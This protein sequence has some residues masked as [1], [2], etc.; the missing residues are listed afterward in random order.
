MR[1][2]DVVWVRVRLPH[3]R[4]KQVLDFT[5]VFMMVVF[6][7]GLLLD[8]VSETVWWVVLG[9]EFTSVAFMIVV[10]FTSPRQITPKARLQEPT[11]NDS[12]P[13]N[14]EDR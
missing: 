7:A 13:P 1:G 4:R 6:L 8:P 10:A 2:K 9:I 3:K 5:V 14:K 12:D 11:S